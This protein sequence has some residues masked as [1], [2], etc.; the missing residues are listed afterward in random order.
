[1]NRNV[2]QV[3]IAD[4][5][6]FFVLLSMTSFATLI[7][8]WQAIAVY[9]EYSSP[10]LVTFLPSPW[11]V[12]VTGGEM[13]VTSSFWHAM[14]LSNVR[15]LAGFTLSTALAVPLGIWLGAF[16]KYRGVAGP[17]SDFGR[18]I[19][20]AAVIPLMILWAGTGELLKTLV[21]F[22][23]TFFPLVVMITDNVRR[24]P[25][26]YVDSALTMGARTKHV[27]LGVLL[28][29]AAP[30][31]YDSL[32]AGMGLTWSY[33]MMAEIV[34]A[35]NGLGFIINYSQ[36]FLRTPQIFFVIIVLGILG[37][38]Y[39]LFFVVTRRILFRWTNDQ[40]SK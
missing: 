38:I 29:A 7:L 2:R 27:V 4:K 8:L 13:L 6:G 21:L 9:I 37:L 40:R 33:L 3:R 17:I 15:V 10:E 39:D 36:K 11:K 19:P 30:A 31:I 35:E 1:M 14:L 32:R 26:E 25:I 18:Y 16:P 24:V 12:V 28:P 5:S 22:L 23:G 34:A 20:V